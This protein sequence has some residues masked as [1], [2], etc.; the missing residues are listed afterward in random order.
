MIQSQKPG[1]DVAESMPKPAIGASEA[2][3]KA[4][5]DLLKEEIEL[6]RHMERVAEQRRALPPGPPSSRKIM[7]LTASARTASQV[8]FDCRICSA[9]AATRS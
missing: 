8:R 3:L 1:R 6:R 4:R 2:Y 9:T 7:S 5:T